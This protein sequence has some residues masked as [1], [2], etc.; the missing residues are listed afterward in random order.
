MTTEKDA[1][2]EWADRHQAWAEAQLARIPAEQLAWD[3]E[4]VEHAAAAYQ[5]GLDAGLNAGYGMGLNVGRA[6][7]FPPVKSFDE[8]TNEEFEA[9]PD[10][11][12][13][14]DY[15]VSLYQATNQAHTRPGPGDALRL[16]G[17][18]SVSD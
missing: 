10:T 5:A 9:H 6:S 4:E 17:T 1:L 7:V 12:E 8:M 15:I 11:P 14:Q 16:G 2:H 13:K 18:Q 3:R